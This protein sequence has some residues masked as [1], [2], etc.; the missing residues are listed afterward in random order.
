VAEGASHRATLTGGRD[1]VH[2]NFDARCGDRIAGA[3]TSFGAC[4]EEPNANALF[5]VE[6]FL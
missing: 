6:L 5:F 1:P 4:P 3:G 2:G